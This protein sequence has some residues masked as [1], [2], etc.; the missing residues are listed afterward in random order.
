MVKWVLNGLVAACGLALAGAASAGGMSMEGGMHMD[1]GSMHMSPGAATSHGSGHAGH[2]AAVDV[3]GCWIR[4]LPSPA[5]S[6]G[7]FVV[8]NKGKRAVALTGASSPAFGMVMLHKSI[9]SGGMSKMVMEHKIPVPAGG[10][11]AFKPGS[12]HAMM[13]KPVHELVVGSTLKLELQ[14]ASGETV[15]TA[16]LVRPAGAMSR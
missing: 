13:E 15:Q 4:A 7:Y 6:A 11:V 8:R 1:G 16:C 3:T 5:P 14:L 9:E 12:Y 10:S 2:A